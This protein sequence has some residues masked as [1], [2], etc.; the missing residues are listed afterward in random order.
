MSPSIQ[1]R[2]W[3]LDCLLASQTANTIHYT[4]NPPAKVRRARIVHCWLGWIDGCSVEWR[5][6]A[7]DDAQRYHEICCWK[8]SS[9]FPGVRGWCWTWNRTAA[10]HRQA[11]S[12]ILTVLTPI[13]LLLSI[14]WRL[15]AF[16]GA[17]DWVV[18]WGQGIEEHWNGPYW[19]TGGGDRLVDNKIGNRL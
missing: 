18:V 11:T 15:E 2:Y 12:S 17:D 16:E 7:G 3:S 9:K 14:C 19:M 6:G 10:T 13:F 5:R 8:L 4:T 1:L